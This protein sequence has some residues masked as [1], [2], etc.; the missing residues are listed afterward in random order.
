M[1]LQQREME[2]KRVPVLK[3]FAR[4]PNRDHWNKPNKEL[5]QQMLKARQLVL[6]QMVYQAEN[7]EN[8]VYFEYH[9]PHE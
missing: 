6:P 2:I 5:Q 7:I 9:K 1:V 8:P 3:E 4:V